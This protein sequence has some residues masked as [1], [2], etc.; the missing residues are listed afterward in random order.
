MIALVPVRSCV[1]AICLWGLGKAT[2]SRAAVSCN[3]LRKHRIAHHFAE[4]EALPG[5]SPA[6]RNNDGMA[7]HRPRFEQHW[8]G[9][10]LTGYRSGI[11]P[12]CARKQVTT[13]GQRPVSHLCVNATPSMTSER[14]SHCEHPC[15][16]GSYGDERKQC[17]CSLS[18]VQRY[19]IAAGAASPARS[20]TAIRP[21]GY[22]EIYTVLVLSII[23]F[24]RHWVYAVSL[25]HVNADFGH[26]TPHPATEPQCCSAASPGRAA[27]RRPAPQSNPYLRCRRLWQD[28]ADR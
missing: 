19:R 13:P 28:Y 27:Q 14:T 20:W 6:R 3:T 26:E 9:S 12:N 23:R 17:T 8:D 2:L 24:R 16:C 21:T 25:R 15:P 10:D 5:R 4:H 11:R 7:N 1:G 18:M 22:Q